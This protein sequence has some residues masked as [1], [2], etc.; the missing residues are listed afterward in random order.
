MLMQSNGSYYLFYPAYIDYNIFNSHLAGIDV[1][2]G[3]QNRLK[4]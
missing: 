3:P 2:G 1:G 4:C